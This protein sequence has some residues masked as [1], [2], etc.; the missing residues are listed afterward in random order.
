MSLRLLVDPGIPVHS[1]TRF[2]S[3]LSVAVIMVVIHG[4]GGS[5][6]GDAGENGASKSGARA[7]TYDRV[8]IEPHT[9]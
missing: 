7:G 3:G 5:L 2:R 6:L 4:Y 8:A 1:S 9:P